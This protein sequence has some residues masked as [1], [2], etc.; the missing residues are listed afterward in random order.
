[1]VQANVARALNQALQGVR[2]HLAKCRLLSGFVYLGIVAFVT[3][4]VGLALPS[5]CDEGAPDATSTVK[6]D[7]DSQPAVSIALPTVTASQAGDS[8]APVS[9]ETAPLPPKPKL[10]PGLVPDHQLRALCDYISRKYKV[11]YDMTAM[12]VRTAH[13]V[14][15]ERRL[16]PLLILA[17]MAIES[18]YDPFAQ[19]SH[20]AQGLMQVMTSV[21]QDKFHPYGK[22]SPLDPVAN[23]NVGAIVLKECI[24]RRGSI[25]GGLAC[26]VGATGPSDNGYSAKVQAERRQLALVSG[27]AVARD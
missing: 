18:R 8:L 7:V 13:K 10:K 22:S 15:W 5:G 12:L 3:V 19:S 11:A 26:Y 24:A 16:D 2:H 14:G 9:K 17:V 23:I 20:G 27:I 21:H 25:N 6:P 1:M 4:S